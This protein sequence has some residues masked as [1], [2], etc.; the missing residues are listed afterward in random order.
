LGFQLKLEDFRVG[1]YQGTRR[2]ASYESD[3]S[4]VDKDAPEGKITIS[5]NEPLKYK[6][7]TFY[8]SSFQEDEMGRPTV[9]ILS[10]NRDPGRPWKYVGSLLLVFGIIHLFWFKSRKKAAS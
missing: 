10:V 8:Q 2:A 5:M 9:S 7:F 4:I 1:R 6:G 3:V